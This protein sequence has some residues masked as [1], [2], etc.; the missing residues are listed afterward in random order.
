[1]IKLKKLYAFILILLISFISGV[2]FA[3]K[4]LHQ[5]AKDGEIIHARCGETDGRCWD[6]IVLQPKEIN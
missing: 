5:I 3:G 4:S 6:I 1:M 2:T